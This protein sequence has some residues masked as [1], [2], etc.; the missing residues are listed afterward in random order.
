[1]TVINSV[2]GQFDSSDL[3]YT[4]THEHVMGSQAGILQ[5]YPEF[6]GPDFME[7]IVT[8][9]VQ[10]KNGGIDTIVDASTFEMGR[11]VSVMA[12][13][14]RPLTQTGWSGTGQPTSLQAFLSGKLNGV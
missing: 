1:M 4:L 5:N 10:A 3:G 6:F 8:G 2:L 11:D 7:S 12:E 13:A 9:L 14:S